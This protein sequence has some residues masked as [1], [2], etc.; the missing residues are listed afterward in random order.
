MNR[1]AEIFD[2]MLKENKIE[3]FRREELTD[4]FHRVLYRSNMEIEG[5]MLP[6]L[7][8]LDDSIYT[9]VRIVVAAKVVKEENKTRVEAHLAGLN[10]HY[11]IFK[12]YTTE[13]GNIVLDCCIPSTNVHFDPELVR[14]VLDVVLQHLQESYKETMKAVWAEG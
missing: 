7:L 1:K 9:I 11:K 14:T 12:Y 8:I 5:Q 4:E 2:A 10:Q 13:D 3:A 6:V